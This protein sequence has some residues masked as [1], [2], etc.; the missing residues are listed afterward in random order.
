M[1]PF[2]EKGWTKD[3]KFEVS[4]SFCGFATIGMVVKLKKDDGTYSPFF[5]RD[6]ESDFHCIYLDSLKKIT[7]SEGW[8]E[9]KG[10]RCPVEKGTLVDVKYRDGI[11]IFSLPALLNPP[12]EENNTF[13]DASGAFWRKHGQRNDIIAYRLSNTDSCNC[14][15]CTDGDDS[16]QNEDIA[17]QVDWSL[18]II[19]LI[20]SV[21]PKVSVSDALEIASTLQEYGFKK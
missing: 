19:T 4:G 15:G 1:T 10:G 18:D 14:D 12:Y 2:E 6:D 5:W 20:S 7:N 3:D 13:R 8:I 9:W 16:D 21:A 11:E 17:E